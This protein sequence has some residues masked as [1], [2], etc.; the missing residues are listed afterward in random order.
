MTAGVPDAPEGPRPRLVHVTTTDISLELLLGPQLE[1]FA[2]AGFEVVGVS[3]PGPFVNALTERGIRHEPLRHATR[4]MAP[5]R[6]AA[7]L[8]EL[9]QLFRRL[10][11]DIVHTH[12][13]K[14]GV[15]GR[16]AARVAGVPVVV[17]TVHGLYATP[18]DP[19]S[20]R[21]VVYT[22]ERVAAACSDAELVQNPEDLATL[23]QV[24]RVPAA[25]LVLLG[26]GVDLGRFAPVVGDTT[27]SAVRAR[28][29]DGWG[30]G[31]DTVVVGAVG[32][33]VLEK[34]YAE[35]FEAWDRV[36]VSHPAARLVVAGPVDTDKA[37]A[38]PPGLLE[39]AEAS[40]VR[41]LGMVDDVEDLYAGFDLY[42]LA[43]HREG[44]PRSA[45]EAAASGLPIVATDIRGCRQVVDNEV[46]G[47]L[48]PVRDP[49]A[50]AAALGRL[51][52]DRAARQRMG[53]AAAA[54]AL[55]DFD[56]R[57][58]IDVTLRTYERLLVARDRRAADATPPAQVGGSPL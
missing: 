47:L 55:R 20:K 36:R 25:K 14:P 10:R 44:F 40:G 39:R 21:A 43:S 42:V 46:T 56:Q 3:A 28:V 22:L 52:D 2:A 35:L 17:N 41:L 7:A 11:P 34:G 4:A 24:L 49:A 33:L 8:G 32:R 9:W 6:D 1:A 58:V 19:W 54:R 27:R 23:R 29:R 16:V 57:R 15:Y 5:H 50:L 13:P 26:N 51:I 38:V 30:A 18:E 37:D 48:V 31:A 12:N 53:A 45:M